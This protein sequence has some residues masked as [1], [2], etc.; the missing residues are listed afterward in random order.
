[1][2]AMVFACEKFRPYILGSQVIVHTD[3]AS[4]KYQMAKKDAKSRLIRWVL[5]LQEFDLEIK[6]KKDSD[7]V[8]TNH[9]SRLEKP[10]DDERGMKLKK[11]SL[12]IIFFKYHFKYHGMLI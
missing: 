9:L 5:L 3:H 11:I 1:M 6:N 8:I 4:F 2:L 7:N 12:M 10:M